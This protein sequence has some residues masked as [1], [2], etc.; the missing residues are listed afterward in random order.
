MIKI[1]KNFFRVLID[2]IL[3][4]YCKIV[5][6][7]EVVGR[8]NI[9]KEGAV[10]FCGNHKSLI[11]PVLINVYTPRNM[12]FLAKE[13]LN[14]LILRPLIK[15]YKII[16]VRRDSKDLSALKESLKTL[17]SGECIALFP[18]GTRNGLEKNNGQ[19]KNGATYLAIKTGAK[20]VPI[21]IKGDMKPFHK[22]IVK[23]G[24]PID[25]SKYAKEKI[26][27]ELEDKTTEEL[28]ETIIQLTK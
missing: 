1:K 12:R 11:D 3:R 21:G 13:E 7:V 17:K 28:K 2:G 4:A 25:Y 19:M 20:I 14:K 22:V 6:R 5:Y 24:N 10:L 18:E 8:E 15:L 9:P 23:Y 27:K 16:L 26:T